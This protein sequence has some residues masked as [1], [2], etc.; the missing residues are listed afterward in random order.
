MKKKVSSFLIGLLVLGF[1]TFGY[2]QV[3][4]NKISQRIHLSPEGTPIQSTTAGS[5]VEWECISRQLTSK[6]IVYHNDQWFTFSTPDP[7]T[8]FLNVSQQVC[9]DLYGIQMSIIDG[10]PC[11]TENYIIKRCISKLRMDDIYVELGMLKANQLYLLNIDGFLGDYCTFDIQLSKKPM[12]IPEIIPSTTYSHQLLPASENQVRIQWYAP[13]SLLSITRD[14]AVY[15]KER[16]EKKYTWLASKSIRSNTV[17]SF[18]HTYEY[19]DTLLVYGVYDFLV[20]AMGDTASSVVLQKSVSWLEEKASP[21]IYHTIRIP[22]T[23]SKP[24]RCVALSE[25]MGR[26]SSRLNTS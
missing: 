22:L 10:N 3:V 17:G 2:G 18:Q 15:R 8:Y 7:G 23:F 4:N 14:F 20:V 9:K 21:V 13:D 24:G 25:S 11:D 5:T 26:T 19:I 1:C 12:G 6:C 16:K